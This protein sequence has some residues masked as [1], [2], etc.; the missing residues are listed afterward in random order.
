M[1]ADY[2]FYKDKEYYY[3]TKI[4]IFNKIATRIV[5]PVIFFMMRDLGP[6]AHKRE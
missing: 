5:L 4:G 2:E 1:P 6:G 3:P